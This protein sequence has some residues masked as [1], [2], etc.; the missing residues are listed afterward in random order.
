[1]KT[2][3]LNLGINNIKSI[4]NASEKICNTKIINDKSEFIDCDRIILPGNGSFQKG[5][6]EIMKRGF[7]KIIKDFFKRKKKII[8]ICLGLQLMMKRSEES[9]NTCGLSL[10][11]GKVIKI[12]DSNLRLPLLGWYDVAFKNN[13]F[14][15]KSYFFNNNY[16]VDVED[17]NLSIGKLNNL[18]AFIKKDNFYGFQFHPEKSG[19]H[20]IEL[21]KKTIYS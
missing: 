17:K 12:N 8:G 19:K 5:M 7:D 9:I 18:S 15:N 3:I 14:Q 10:I 11:N 2:I 21:L 6:E 13:M 20:G 16:I 4:K 1:M